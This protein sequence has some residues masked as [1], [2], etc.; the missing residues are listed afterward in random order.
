MTP[1]GNAVSR[2]AIVLGAGQGIGQATALHL[3][4]KGFVAVSC[5][6]RRG[7]LEAVVEESGAEKTAHVIPGDITDPSFCEKP[8]TVKAIAP[9][10][11]RNGFGRIV[12]VVG[13]A[14]KEPAPGLFLSGLVNAA[15]ANTGTYLASRHA[16]HGVTVNS[17]HPGTVRTG[18][19]DRALHHLSRSAGIPRAEAEAR[20]RRTVPM[21]R[22]GEAHEVAAVIG[23]LASEE[24]AC[25]TGQQISVEGGQLACP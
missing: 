18:R 12:D 9:V 25:L 13:N 20:L 8:A 4:G 23:F 6:R 7:A 24:A 19:Y 5:A 10:M 15:V 16:P 1:A 2:V 11:P 14:G 17:V 22:P 21:D 3:N